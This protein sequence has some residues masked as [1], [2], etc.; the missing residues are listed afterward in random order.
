[1]YDASLI[2]PPQFDAA[3]SARL[4]RTRLTVAIPIDLAW[5]LP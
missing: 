1:L 3:M 2:L 4:E 5:G